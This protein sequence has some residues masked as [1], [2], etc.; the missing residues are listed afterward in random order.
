MEET[1]ENHRPVESHCKSVHVFNE[2]HLLEVNYDL[3]SQFY[4]DKIK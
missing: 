4:N 2:K 1:G 3:V